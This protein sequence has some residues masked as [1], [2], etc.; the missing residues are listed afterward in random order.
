MP[1]RQTETRRWAPALLAIGLAVST[2]AALPAETVDEVIAKHIEARGGAEA[3]SKIHSLKATGSFTAFSKVNPFTLHRKRDN[4]YHLDHMLGDLQVV[5]GYDG[6]TAW[7]INHWYQIPWPQKITGEDLKVTMQD[8]DLASPFFDY[9]KKGYKVELQGEGDLEGQTAIK[10]G[11]T[12]ADGSAETW[13]LDPETY[14]EIGYD[15]GG[16]DFGQPRPQRAYIEDFRK[17]G[18]VMIPHFIE[19]QWYTRDRIM[20]IHQIETNIEIDDELFTMPLP[21]GMAQLATLAGEWS[22]QGEARQDPQTPW[23]KSEWTSTI[24]SR[25]GGA[26]LEEHY[27]SPQGV[28]VV[29]SLSY[30]RFKERYRF[31][32]F[33]DFTSHLDV[34]EGTM[35]DGRLTVSNAE[36]GTTW[37]GF[38]QTFHQRLTI[39]DVTADGFKTEAE[40]SV[41]G[42]KTWA[43]NEKATYTRTKGSATD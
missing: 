2:S 43:V 11:L 26:M 22:V 4:K 12:R 8:I 18:E 3:W 36:T 14:L 27:V 16:S 21:G 19:K 25:M 30:D 24:E 1:D 20:E 13:Y 32:Q 34:R 38:D 23:A 40:Q 17:V 10:V 39:F 37:T 28:E 33:S 35:D 41:D 15:G 7:W 6:E 29:R 5:I 31:S 9:E 42:G